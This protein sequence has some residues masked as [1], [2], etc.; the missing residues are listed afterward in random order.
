MIEPKMA[1]DVPTHKQIIETIH[2]ELSKHCKFVSSEY[3]LPSGERADIVYLDRENDIN[4]IEVKTRCV[5]AEFLQSIKKYARWCHR[6]WIAAPC[7]IG[8]LPQTQLGLSIEHDLL[9]ACGILSIQANTVLLLRT[10]RRRAVND[11]NASIVLEALVTGS[12]LVRPH[13]A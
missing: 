2:K 13:G 6:L 5:T 3:W 12:R 7:V 10:P 9:A 1:Y 11:A 8:D 4:I